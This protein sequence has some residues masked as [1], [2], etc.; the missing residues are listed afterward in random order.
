MRKIAHN[1]FVDRLN[2]INPNVEVLGTYVAA[3]VKIECKC[4]IDNHIWLA[5]PSSLLTGRGCPK[6]GKNYRKTHEEFVE[7]LNSIN[8]NIEIISEYINDH[9]KVKCKCKI[10]NYIWSAIPNSLLRGKGCPKC[11]NHIHKT[12]DMF[13][14]EMKRISPDIEF[15]EEYSHC[16]RKIKCRCK[17]K[18]HIWYATP[19][20]LRRG[21]NCPICN[22]SKG[23]K[24]IC[25]FLEEKKITFEAQKIFDGLIGVGGKSLSYDFYLP[26]YRLLIEY[27]GNFHDNTISGSYKKS[28]NY[29]TQIEHDNR[30]YEFAKRNNIDLL[31][32]W[33][34]DY[35][36]IESILR[37]KLNLDS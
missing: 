3:K 14:L 17:K 8:S 20:N 21:T 4:K 15:L 33:Y 1:D 22:Y 13:I 18:G 23:E 36:N 32:I 24:R 28:F 31:E 19:A 25:S 6:C 27:Q 29:D 34:Q 10:D 12:H 7:Q 11:S 5:T 2:I 37:N 30:K 26:D 35:T 9:T 16:E